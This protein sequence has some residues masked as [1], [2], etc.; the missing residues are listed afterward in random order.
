MRTKSLLIVLLLILSTA[1]TV[2]SQVP[3]A[4]NTGG[5]SAPPKN[6]KIKGKIIDADTKS[7][8]EYANVSIYRKQDAKLVTGAIANE[9]GLFE[10]ADLPFGTYYVE[11][12][13][14]GFE[15]T[16]VNDI[17]IIPN[18]TSVDM[19]TIELAVSRQNIGT[20]DVVAERNRVEYKIDK[21]VINVT[22]DINAAGGS[23]VT[24]LENTPSVEVDIDG[25]VS[26]RGSSSFTVLID[27]RPSVLS[28][29]D[30][31]KQIPSSAIQNIEII[32]NPSVKYDP[33][34]MAGIINVVMKKNVLSGVNGIINVNLGT[35]E[36]Y[37]T[38]MMLNYKTK[39]YN[40]FFGAN[41]ND[42][43]DDGTMKSTRETYQNDT[44]TFLVTD[45]QRDM[46][47]GG[48]QLK[49]GFDYYLTDKT[50]VTVSGEIGQYNFGGGGGGNLHEY[51]EPGDFNLYTVQEN[52]SSREGNYVSGQ[53][54]FLT[55]FDEM[56]THKLEGSF[57]YRNRDGLSTE[58]IDEFISDAN[59]S[60]TNNYLSR[61]LTNEDDNSNDY[62]MKIDYTLPLEKGAKF[63]AG[64]QSRMERETELFNFKNYNPTSGTFEN[65]PLFTSDMDFKEDIHSIYSTYS[66]NVKAIQYMIGL[67]GEY[68]KRS[69]DHSKVT[70][71]YTLD[72]FDFFPSAH[73][74]Y[75]LVDKSQF[76]TS[77]SRRINRPGGRDLDPFPNYMNQYTIRIGNPD[78]KPEYTDSYEFSYMRKFGNSF[79][80]LETFYRT[81]NDLITRIQELKED[82]IIYMSADNL[83]RDHSLGGEIMGNIN[84]TK[85]L[86]VNTS[87]SLYNYK[88]KGE[89]LGKSV[90]RESTNYS[91]R[92]N[93][94]IKFSGD[95]RMQLTGFYRGPSVSAQGDQK[96]MIFTN[97][98]YRQDFMKKKLSATL[99][100]RDLLGT[101]KFEGTSFGDDFKSS[102]KMQREPRVLMLTLSYKINN[103][104]MDKQAPSEQQGQGGMDEMF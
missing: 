87:F 2:L 65:N 44:T 18:S 57:D 86:L 29:S 20:V 71:P 55:K 70:E 45:G 78:L 81:T 5:M 58:T 61:V 75:E 19:G 33:D 3:P 95:S 97:L 98:S 103:Y 14:I 1:G 90:D 67:R 60:Q 42:N 43:T 25:N 9:S 85:W 96:G 51:R 80:S 39:K 89:V 66:G 24:V 22:N 11:A 23:A 41:W 74:S 52:Y 72:R 64:L 68:T 35:G 94:T 63:E 16:T 8:M 27:G 101:A 73:F 38:D 100:V 49:G 32:T 102:F 83:N 56:G 21:K 36:K 92:L 99:S 37:G 82:G 40:L 10:I 13:F 4:A 88:L 53:A 28:G 50:S 26:L 91:G 77:Y 31:L 69:I 6:G 84:I 7:A 59:F 48:K 62:R 15:K 93:A 79:V 46:N 104:K 54:S 17:K 12:G 47:R 34:G 30:A 76:M